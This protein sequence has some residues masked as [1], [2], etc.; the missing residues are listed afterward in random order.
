MGNKNFIVTSAQH[1]APIQKQLV[2]SLEQLAEE[3]DAEIV[4]IT[5]KTHKLDEDLPIGIEDHT[6][7]AE[8]RE[9]RLNKKI[10]AHNYNI[11]T[12]QIEPTTGIARFTQQDVSTIVG[13]PKQRVKVVPNSVNSLPKTLITTGTITLPTYKEGFRISDIA[14]RDHVMGAVYVE[15]VNGI[16]YHYRHLTANS[17][18][19]FID[20]GIRYNGIKDPLPTKLEAMVLGDVHVGEHDQK[21][22]RASY[23]MI[24]SLR[25][26]RIILHDV[27]NGHSVCH[28]Y[29]DR[30]VTKAKVSRMGHSDLE[31][32]LRDVGAFL[33]E[34]YE[35]SHGAEIVVV[36][37]NH[38]DFLTKYL[39]SGRFINDPLNA[40]IGGKLFVAAIEGQDPVKAGIEIF[41]ELPENIRF[42]DRQED[43]KVR[44]WQLGVHGDKGP[45]GAWNA[46]VGALEAAYGKSIT[47]HKHTP[48]LLR[49]T[50]VVG[51]LTPIRVDYNKGPSSWMNTNAVLY[52]TGTI[53]LINIINGKWKK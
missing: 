1:N 21:A 52:D 51:T 43:Y 20:L 10:H 6:V 38:H 44:G 17:Q 7:L 28:H 27:F 22:L 35:R 25:P 45:N 5:T 8:N 42:L 31:E 13:S 30:A 24:E 47:G 12:Q 49:K 18:G 14:K 48:E 50:A 40:H 41:T 16:K 4:I 3:R 36:A 11:R 33:K 15:V 39:E 34:L 32:E 26:K 37:C 19:A 46:G 23:E 53:Q 9:L 2:K 29:A